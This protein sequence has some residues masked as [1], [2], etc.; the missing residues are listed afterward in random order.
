MTDILADLRHEFERHKRL[1]DR[2]IAQ[3]DDREFFDRPGPL[4][5]PVALIVKHLA[6]NL[7]SRW[8]DFLT[9]DGEKATRD[10]DREFVLGEQDTRANLCAAWEQGWRTLFETL[11]SLQE[12]DLT[13]SVSIRGESH[14]AQQALLR[15]MTHVA[16]H[17]GQM[18]YLVRLLRPESPW[19]S[20]PP[21]QS[22]RVGG[23]YRKS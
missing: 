11:A 22:S 9:T 5:N 12:T 1:A 4:V 15:G 18:L 16:Y 7:S 20:I 10:R 21:G 19:L 6:G 23:N 13:K 3:L 17:T 14:T 2:A 8:T